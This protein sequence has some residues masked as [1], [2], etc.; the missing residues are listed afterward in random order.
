MAGKTRVDDLILLEIGKRVQEFHNKAARA[1]FFPHE[2]QS[3]EGG[4]RSTPIA[5]IA[6]IQEYGYPGGNL[7][8][9]PFMR[10]AMRNNRYEFLDDTKRGVRAVVNG[11]TNAENVLEQMGG[12]MAASIQKAIRDVNSPALSPVTLMLRGM[13]QHDANLVVTGRTVGEAARRVA[14]GKTNYNPATK[15]LQDTGQMI[16][17][18]TYKVGKPAS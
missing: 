2:D 17:S 9:R 8:P 12:K 6:A 7:P 10:P 16:A 13:K 3:S 15:P 18:V 14:E 4:A 11:S 1:G 5:Y